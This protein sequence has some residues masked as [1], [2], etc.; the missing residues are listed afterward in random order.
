MHCDFASIVSGLKVLYLDPALSE[1]VCVSVFHKH[2][3]VSLK[4]S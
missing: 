2:T 3:F 1:T 4:T